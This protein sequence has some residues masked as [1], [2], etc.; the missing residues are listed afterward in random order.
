MYPAMGKRRMGRG[1]E[2]AGIY[3][4]IVLSPCASDRTNNHHPHMLSAHTIGRSQT[5][6]QP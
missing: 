3:Q 1:S 2:R 4:L 6:E 5:L